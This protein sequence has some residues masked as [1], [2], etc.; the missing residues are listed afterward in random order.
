MENLLILNKTRNI[1]NVNYNS[2]HKQNYLSKNSIKLP[3]L[4]GFGEVEKI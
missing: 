2:L 4:A 3:I 1:K